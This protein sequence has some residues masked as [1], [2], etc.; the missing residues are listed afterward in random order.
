MLMFW[1]IVRLSLMHIF[2]DLTRLGNAFKMADDSRTAASRLVTHSS[3]DAVDLP[4]PKNLIVG[5]P[6][7]PNFSPIGPCSSAFTCMCRMDTC[8]PKDSICKTK[9]ET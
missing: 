1:D 9:L 7:T 2:Q 8:K 5:N 4:R 6:R 3:G